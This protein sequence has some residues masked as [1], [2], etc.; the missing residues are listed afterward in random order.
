MRDRDVGWMLGRVQRHLG[1]DALGMVERVSRN[2]FEVLVA[3]LLSLRTKDE[4]TEPAAARLLAEASD[5]AA[6]LRLPAARI[7]RLIYPVGFYRRKADQLREI[8]RLLLERHGGRVPD[9]LDALLAL[10]GVGRKTAN[11]VLSAGFGLPGICV[12]THVH[13]ITNRWGYVATRHPDETELALRAKLPA[14]HWPTINRLLV[15]FG[16]SVCQPVSPRCSECPV[17][18]RC[19]R[20]GVGRHR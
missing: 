10:P 7:A 19:A 13:R 8:A 6:M 1:A 15:L 9:D 12:D 3:T 5:P 18:A 16:K 11:L 20:C 2:P 4:T 14:R 17:A